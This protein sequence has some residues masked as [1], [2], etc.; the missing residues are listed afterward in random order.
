MDIESTGARIVG[1]GN[2]V[3]SLANVNPQV[4][5]GVNLLNSVTQTVS[6]VT[7]GSGGKSSGLLGGVLGGVGGAAN[8]IGGKQVSKYKLWNIKFSKDILMPLVPFSGHWLYYFG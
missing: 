4:N 6:G 1:D 2:T 3:S 8:N 5:A 7:G